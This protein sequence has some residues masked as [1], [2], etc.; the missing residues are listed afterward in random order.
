MLAVYLS[1]VYLIFHM[2][3]GHR[4]IKWLRACHPFFHRKWPVSYTH[5]DVD[6]R[7]HEKRTQ[8]FIAHL[9]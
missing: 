9:F 1:P 4:L 8:L 6:K 5:L 3:I 7:Q 2:Y